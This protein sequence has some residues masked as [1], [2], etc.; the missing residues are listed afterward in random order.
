M[1]V[2][3][4]THEKTRFFFRRVIDANFGGEKTEKFLKKLKMGFFGKTRFFR[5]NVIFLLLQIDQ[6]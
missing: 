6:N 3:A 4:K 2:F 5:K 1:A